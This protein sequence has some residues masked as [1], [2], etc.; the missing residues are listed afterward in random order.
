MQCCEVKLISICLDES[1]SSRISFNESDST[2]IKQQ[3]TFSHSTHRSINER[4]KTNS[5]LHVIVQMNKRTNVRMN[6]RM[7]VRMNKITNVRMNKRTNVRM[8]KI[9]N[10]RMNKRTNVIY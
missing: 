3:Q 7:N 1:A 8:N 10:V 5:I 9:T 4:E 2:L 6:K